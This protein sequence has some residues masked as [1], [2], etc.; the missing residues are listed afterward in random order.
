MLELVL[1]ILGFTFIILCTVKLIY[2]VSLKA[3]SYGAENREILLVLPCKSEKN[4]AGQICSALLKLPLFAGLNTRIVA[5]DCGLSEE[6]KEMC[7]KVCREYGNVRL[8]N[9]NELPQILTEEE[10]E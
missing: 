10:N 3:L 7:L 9:P 4:C 8:C 2:F 1:E 5:V 6:E